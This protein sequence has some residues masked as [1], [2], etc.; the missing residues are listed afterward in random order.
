MMVASLRLGGFDF[1]AGYLLKGGLTGMTY[2]LLAVGLVLVYRS[3]NF[4][5]FAHI[6]AG[7]FGA[8]ILSK[9]ALP[10]SSDG[11]G[12]PFWLAMAV[13]MMVGAAVSVAN[14]VIV[15]RPLRKSPRVL[16]M[17][18]TLGMG[19]FFFFAALAVNADGLQPL[20]F[21]KPTGF[22]TFR[23]DPLFVD[24]FDSAQLILSPILL[25]ALALFLT[26]T[27][28]GIAIRGAA[29]N[30]DAAAGAGVSPSAMAILSWGLAGALAVYSAALLIPSKGAVTPASIGPDLLLR[31]LAAAALVR[32]RSIGGA[33]I[34]A[35]GIGVT[36]AVL[37]SNSNANGWIEIAILIAVTISLLV[38]KVSGRDAPE[39]WTSLP[40]GERLPARYRAVWSIR[41]L[42]SMVG[43]TSFV[44]L[45]AVPFFVTNSTAVAA[46]QALALALVG[47][48]VGIIT[49]LGGQLTLGQFA[50]GGIGAAV[51]VIVTQHSG[52]FALGLVAAMVAS[53]LASLAVGFPALRV[54]G[55]LLGVATLSFA[56]FCSG[57]LFGQ[58]WMF[59][60]YRPTNVPDL[61]IVDGK[62]R[63]YYW[64]ALAALA[65]AL[66][67]TRNLRRGA[68]GRKLVAVRD[69]A[70][71]ARALSVSATR[72]KLQATLVAGMLAGLG[73]AIFAQSAAS[74][75]ADTISVQLS[76]DA[77]VVAVVGGI[78]SLAGPL[79]GALY[80]SGIP[81]ILNVTNNE[82]LAAL[83]AGWLILLT[84][85]P[86]GIAGVL[87]VVFRRVEDLLARLHGIDPAEARAVPDGDERPTVT[88]AG[89]SSTDRSPAPSADAATERTPLL[90]VRGLTRR[91]GGL[92]A[93][94]DVSFDVYPGETVGMIGPNGAGKTTLFELV[95]GFT[96]PDGGTVWFDGRNVTRVAPEIRS[97]LG[98]VRSFQ[99]AT[100][101]PTLTLLDTVMVAQERS[102]PS[103][104][105]ESVIGVTGREHVREHEARQ[106]IDLFGLSRFVDV[107]ISA[108]PTGTRRLVELACTVALRPRLILLDEPSAGIA[109]AETEELGRVLAAIRDAYDV[110]FVVI[111]HDMPLLTSIC[112]RMIALEV[113]HVI[114]TG[115]PSEVQNHPAVVESYLG[116]NAIAVARSGAAADLV[117]ETT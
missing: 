4:I 92:V 93:V 90:S 41:N 100:L 27:R 24:T 33:V 97:R 53:G 106:I 117:S 112:D 48:S 55:L 11:Y 23:V 56:L 94:D 95:C 17:V 76:I 101:F 104:L 12:F 70:D 68:F 72:V 9:L 28:Y 44:A 87:A 7:L 85:Q 22:P 61:G 59:G 91:F 42:G 45:A 79:I 50:I 6:G 82:A 29:S 3:S 67:I 36:E 102:H 74:V 30:R 107:Q 35:L 83:S 111:E 25:I 78:G 105:I 96:R 52:S 15:V 108:L 69:N 46:N 66:L 20:V 19:S 88:L 98:M 89:R 115:T 43:V 51:A 86:A 2:A 16:S 18:A 114:T 32:F 63:N 81:S 57:W 37:A 75:S 99:S 84:Y 62:D 58:S 60:G 80:I 1:G 49:G 21:P 110:T 34:A 38:V 109:Q 77:V 54:R 5:N 116:D 71:A 65:F 103:G 14:E 47:T 113:G 31:A 40:T 10:E 8:S 13:A 26:R 64:I 73:A 39:P